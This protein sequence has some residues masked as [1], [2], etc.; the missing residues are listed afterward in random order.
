[1]YTQV[2]I[3]HLLY[4]IFQIF[5]L[6]NEKRDFIYQRILKLGSESLTQY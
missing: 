3:Y 2:Y 1:M 5:K 4:Y 6:Q